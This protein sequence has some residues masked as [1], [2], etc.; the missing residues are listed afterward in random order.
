MEINFNT[1]KKN[2]LVL[3]LSDEDIRKVASLVKLQTVKDGHEIVRLG[4]K[5]PDIFIILD[6]TAMVFR[7]GGMLL[8]ARPPGSVIG[9]IALVDDQPRSAYVIAKGAVTYAHIEG[10]TL[11][12][13]MYQNKDIG[14]IM[15]SNLA[16]ILAMR[17]REASESI[18]DL[19]GQVA[20]LW[21][22]KD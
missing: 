16:R 9:E 21:L 11:R 4:A 17:L 13:F 15:L 2:Y 12:R 10:R 19:R 1:F 7:K 14:F 5:D 3:G 22:Y 18:E 20:D 6:G 8:G